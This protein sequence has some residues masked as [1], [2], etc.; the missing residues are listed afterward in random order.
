VLR[1]R[2]RKQQDKKLIESHR[3]SFH[4]KFKSNMSTSRN[5]DELALVFVREQTNVD[6]EDNV[7]TQDDVHINALCFEKKLVN[8]IDIDSIITDFVS[9]NFQRKF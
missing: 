8:E 9:R 5:P 1:K 3:G 7:G 4:K 6:P 2:E